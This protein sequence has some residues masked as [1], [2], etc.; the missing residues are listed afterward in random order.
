MN[1]FKLIT[2]AC[3]A[4]LVG[5]QNNQPTSSNSTADEQTQIEEQDNRINEEEANRVEP[6]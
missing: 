6:K 3:F 1:M 4:I 2:V 5:C